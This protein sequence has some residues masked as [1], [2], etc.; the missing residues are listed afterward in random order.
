MTRAHPIA[1]SLGILLGL[2][3]GDRPDDV[4][5][6]SAA[7]GPARSEEVRAAIVAQERHTRAL[8]RIPGVLGTAVGLLPN[9]RAAVRIFVTSPDVPGLPPH[10]HGIPV[11]RHVTGL[12]VAFGDP[13]TR[14]RPAPLGYSVGHP[15][16]TSGTI[17]A[18]VRDAAGNVYVL[19]NNHVL[20]AANG[21]GLGDA[22]LQ[23]GPFDGGGAA[24]QIGTL[25]AF[26][27]LDFSFGSQNTMD[28]AIA[29]SNVADLGNATP[30]DDGYGMP[31]S[32]IFGDADADGVFDDKT[33]LLGVAVQKYGRTTKLTRGQVTGINGTVQICYEVLLLFCAK[34]AT[35]VDQLIIEPGAFSG[36]GDSGAL[37]VTDDAN[38]NP[39]ALLFA[40]TS[41]ATVANRIDLVLNHFGVTV[42]G[43]AAPPPRPRSRRSG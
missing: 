7:F 40:G 42:D 33:A 27:A 17:G 25:F 9:G 30:S 14:A 1:L 4:T 32:G 2:A 34:S 3:C 24:D 11:T 10:L 19:S 18:R 28:A 21:A 16:I 36:G 12:F 39:V 41:T 23:P 8:L 6:P 29:L 26:K 20:A 35:F 43:A 38:K 22:T 15:L 37:I 5:G 13:T 31:A